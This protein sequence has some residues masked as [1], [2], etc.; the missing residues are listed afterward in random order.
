VFEIIDSDGSGTL[1]YTE[2]LAAFE[3]MQVEASR[4]TA[5][6]SAIDT[7]GSGEVHLPQ[8]LLS[9]H[10]TYPSRRL[11]VAGLTAGVLRRVRAG[12]DA[13]YAEPGNATSTPSF[14]TIPLSHPLCR[15]IGHGAR[16]HKPQVRLT[17]H[18]RCGVAL[19]AE[20]RNG[21]THARERRGGGGEPIPI[22]GE[23]LPT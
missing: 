16:Y 2:L 15:W 21:P 6:V 23:S 7:D 20:E 10:Q 8:Q 5:V 9:V 1:G 19:S 12:D 17:S 14:P 18:S 4:A 13:D 11:S 3:H 22:A